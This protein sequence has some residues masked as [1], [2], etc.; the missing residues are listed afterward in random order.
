[1]SAGDMSWEF[2]VGAVVGLGGV[3]VDRRISERA[4]MNGT[5]IRKQSRQLGP[6]L[7]RRIRIRVA[8]RKPFDEVRYLYVPLVARELKVSSIWSES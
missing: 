5:R 7:T 4:G 2:R 6:V 8:A 1:M 3:V